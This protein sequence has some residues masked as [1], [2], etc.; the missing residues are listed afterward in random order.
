MIDEVQA[1]GI[2]RQKARD[3]VD[4]YLDKPFDPEEAAA[5][6]LERWNRL[7]VEAA[8]RMNLDDDPFF[9]GDELLEDELDV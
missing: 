2:E 1:P 3:H 5:F 4:E 6:E 7:N 9:M 8:R